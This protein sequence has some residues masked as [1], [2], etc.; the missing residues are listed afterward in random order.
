FSFTAAK[1]L[2]LSVNSAYNRNEIQFIPDGNLANGFMLNVNR[3]RSGNFKTGRLGECDKY[4]TRDTICV[5][6]E[7]LFEQEPTSSQDHFISGLTLQWSP[8]AEFSNRFAVGYDYNSEDNATVQPF[9]FV[10]N[11]PG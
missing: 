5:A 9:G 6:N 11:P 4:I 2:I 8:V 10:N 7:Y 1:N 3:G